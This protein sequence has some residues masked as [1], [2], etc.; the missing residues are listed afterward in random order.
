MRITGGTFRSRVVRVPDIQGVRPTSSKVRQ[1][2]FNILGDIEGCSGL[3]LF[4]GSGIMAIEAL[5]RGAASMVSIEAHPAVCRALQN[6]CDTF[7]LQEQWHIHKGK[8]PHRL[9]IVA[10]QS[11]DFI[12]AD[13]PY[14]DHLSQDIPAWLHTHHIRCGCLMIEASSR[15]APLLLP[16]W[17]IDSRTY[18]D[19]RIDVCYAPTDTSEPTS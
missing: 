17:K 19:T 3:D 8:L 1:A 5:S 2:L 15:A 10:N 7:Q 13:P 9:D 4:S 14:A 12:F 6:T 16:D 11:F 18:G